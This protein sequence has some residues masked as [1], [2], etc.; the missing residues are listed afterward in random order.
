MQ[1]E[2]NSLLFPAL[3]LAGGLL[4][5]RILQ[6]RQ[7]P[8][9]IEKGMRKVTQDRFNGYVMLAA[10]AMIL[11]ACIIKE[12]IVA[13]ALEIL[14]V[15]IGGLGWKHREFNKSNEKEHPAGEGK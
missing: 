14:G 13:H 15:A 1:I 6:A 11:I 8:A 7:N 5:G 10:L 4:L 2:L 3:A 9:P 12:S